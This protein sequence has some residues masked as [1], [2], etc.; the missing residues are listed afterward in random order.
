VGF[1]IIL[2][3]FIVIYT[4]TGCNVYIVRTLLKRWTVFTS[5]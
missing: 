5:T 2:T 1:T 4:N 3:H